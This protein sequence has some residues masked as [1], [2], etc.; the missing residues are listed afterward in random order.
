MTTL[1]STLPHPHL[2][3]LQLSQA[4]SWPLIVTIFVVVLFC[5][6]LWPIVHCLRLFFHESYRNRRIQR[7]RTELEI[8]RE[9]SLGDV[10]FGDAKREENKYLIRQLCVPVSTV[11]E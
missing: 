7:E 9:I 10:S 3:G 2:R 5:L 11:S 6:V 1:Q 8:A 4:G